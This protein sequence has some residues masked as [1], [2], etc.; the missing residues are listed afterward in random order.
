MGTVSWGNPATNDVPMVGDF[1]GDGRS[2][3]AVYTPSRGLWSLW[4]S[5]T[6]SSMGTVS[7]GNPATNDVPM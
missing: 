5:R 6:Q 2:D 4:S 1:D 7:W 3:V